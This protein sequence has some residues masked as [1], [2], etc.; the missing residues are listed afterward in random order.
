[1][2]RRSWISLSALA[3]PLLFLSAAWAQ[4][5][6]PAHK[7]VKPDKPPITNQQE[8]DAFNALVRQYEQCID[9]YVQERR[10]IAQAHHEAAEAAVREWNEYVA[11]TL[12][13]DK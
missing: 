2:K 7:C 10:Q 3:A 9:E 1:M 11:G 13:P 4:E 8:A 12:N 5:A 6:P